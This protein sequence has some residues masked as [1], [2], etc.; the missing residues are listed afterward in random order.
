MRLRVTGQMTARFFDCRIHP[1]Y[2]TFA[3]VE[4]CEYA[5]RQAILPFLDADEDAVGSAVALD[6]RSAVPVG[7]L[8]SITARVVEVEGRRLVC[9]VEVSWNGAIAAEGTV[10]Q[11]VVLRRKLQSMIEGIYQPDH[12][13][14]P[15]TRTGDL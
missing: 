7:A 1:L 8:V 3:I 12:V 4:H 14:E 13:Q 5:S 10:E 6:H 15:A 11:R 2:A 9:R